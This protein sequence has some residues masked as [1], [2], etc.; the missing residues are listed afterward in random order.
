MPTVV[1]VGAPGSGKSTIGPL[2][3][4]ALGEEFHD[5]DS[6]IEA[7]SGMSVPDIFVLHG[8]P[9]FRDLEREVVLGALAAAGGVLAL[10]GGAVESAQVR[11]ALAGRNVVWVHVADSEAVKRVGLSGPR[12]VLLGN[13]RGQWAQLV[14][15]RTPWYREVA[16]WH[17]DTTDREP[18]AV[19]EEISDLLRGTT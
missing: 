8:E 7:R 11:A 18:D 5:S 12:P 17:I 15:Q 4:A 1:L 10:G 6:L 14:E 2:L 13:L 3:A 16:R 19:A 9:F